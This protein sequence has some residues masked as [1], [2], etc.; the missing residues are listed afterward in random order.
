[1]KN[2]LKKHPALAEASDIMLAILSGSFALFAIL[3]VWIKE[4][5]YKKKA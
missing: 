3:F 2:Y 1:M 4:V 5:I